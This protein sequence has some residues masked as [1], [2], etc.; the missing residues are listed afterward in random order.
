MITDP[1]FYFVAFFAVGF[2]GLSKGGFTGAGLISMPLLVLVVAPLEAAAFM[3]PLLLVQD[4]F[5]IRAFWKAWD[6]K[7]LAL[8]LPAGL[9][10]IVL[11]GLLVGLVDTRYVKLAIGV[12][13]VAFCLHYWMSVK[14]SEDA[15][16]NR[17]KAYFWGTIA[18]FTSFFIHAGGTPYNIYMLPR[19]GEK[20]VFAGT[21]AIFFATVNLAK[22]P[23]YLSLGTL[24]MNALKTAAV[25]IPW[26]ILSNWLGVYM[27]KRISPEKFRRIIYMLT[28]LVGLKLLYDG[29]IG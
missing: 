28:F 17:L 4:A 12:I 1:L 8:M 2:Y 29:F 10:G 16:H 5:S 6:K 23:F 20:L 13:S 25:L 18:G 27:L 3:L 9:A 11:G 7:A 24:N 21:S 22:I 26:A 14:K 19:A 15:P